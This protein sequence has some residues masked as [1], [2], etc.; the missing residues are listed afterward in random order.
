M[1]LIV[2]LG[3]PGK[4]Y[5]KNRHNIGFILLDEYIKKFNNIIWKNKFNSLYTK[6]NI[7]G[8]EVFFQKPLTYMNL[9]GNAIIEITN[10]FKIENKD[11]LVIHDDL[12]IKIGEIKIK[13]NG[14]S[15]GQNGIKSI[16][17]VLGENFN[18]LRIG[19]DRPKNENI[20]NHVLGNFSKE[21]FE[22]IE[23]IKENAFN[24]I[25]DFISGKEIN[26]LSSK[27]N[28]KKNNKK[29]NKKNK[30][31]EPKLRKAKLKDLE[32][33]LKL[34]D[35]AVNYQKQKEIPQWDQNYP[36]LEIFNQDILEE[37][38]YIL[39]FNGNIIGYAAL[40][41][42]KEL[43]YEN[44]K[45]ID[46]YSII[47]RLM[48]N[49]SFHNKGY[50]KLFIEKLIRISIRDSRFTIFTD[51]HEKNESMLNLLE[52]TKFIYISKINYSENTERLAFRYKL[53]G[54]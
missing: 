7:N 33:I 35:N 43:A 27:Y 34:K 29:N 2:G 23:K 8:E 45:E 3:N 21:E 10:F 15:G 17:S 5:E 42:K 32:E 52:K 30:N 22:E 9:S 31:L 4:E 20:I 40:S 6:I 11:I 18:R 39:E 25:S 12:D 44:I 13:A 53:G 48:I 47:H 19:I 51:T 38:G 14:S 50:A 37:I 1:K 28:I 54:F 26:N 41:Y 16:I 46:N 36:N 24:I 49:S